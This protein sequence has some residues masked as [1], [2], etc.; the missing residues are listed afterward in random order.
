MPERR[1]SPRLCAWL[2]S[3]LAL[4]HA[5]EQTPALFGLPPPAALCFLPSSLPVPAGHGSCAALRGS[6]SLV[7]DA[8]GSVIVVWSRSWQ[9]GRS[10]TLGCVFLLRR[11]NECPR[12]RA[13]PRSQLSASDNLGR[14]RFCCSSALYLRCITLFCTSLSLQRQVA[15]QGAWGYLG[16]R[17]LALGGIPWGL[18]GS[19][20]VT[21]PARGSALCCHSPH[22]SSAKWGLG[23]GTPE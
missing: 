22:F 18:L 20:G 4:V 8:G 23:R 5:Q 6:E 13:G 7:V 17:E 12:S 9:W 19:P 14:K 11:C 2:C 21:S 3:S 10:P 15:A 1:V 16:G